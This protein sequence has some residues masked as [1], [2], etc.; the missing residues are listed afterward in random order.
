MAS[1][2]LEERLEAAGDDAADRVTVDLD[3][4][5]PGRPLDLA[6]RRGSDEGD[7]DSPGGS[8]VEHARSARTERRVVRIDRIAYPMRSPDRRGVPCG[9]MARPRR[10]L[11]N[12]PA[13]TTS[14]VGRRRELAELRRALAKARLVSLVGPGGVGKTRLALRAATDLGRGF[15][16][17]AWWVDLA[18][19]RDAA[20]VSG[21]VVA[22][23]DLRDQAG[24]QPLQILSSYLRDR[25]LLLLFD[26]C[27]HVLDASAALVADILR[28]APDVRVIATSREPLQ[29]SG[30]ARRPGAAAGASGRGRR[31]NRSPG[32]SRTKPSCCS[33]S[34][35]R[36]H[37]GRSS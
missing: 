5:D 16:D 28:A 3:L 8:V 15:A 26:N 37:R 21:A 27:E 23:L 19:V 17:G 20:L 2:R 30:R 13:E 14:F 1:Q 9:A 31:G 36:R 18:E 11:G 4:R 10:R 6:G 7:L 34:E 25:E 22:A 35:P 33:R 29:V 24:A 32:S 12:L